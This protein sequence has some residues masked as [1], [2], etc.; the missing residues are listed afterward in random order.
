MTSKYRPIEPEVLNKLLE[1]NKNLEEFFHSLRRY[2]KEECNSELDVFKILQD[3]I[4]GR[5]YSKKEYEALVKINKELSFN[6]F[7]GGVYLN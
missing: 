4:V 2:N 7:K 6:H 3:V 5:H 1:K